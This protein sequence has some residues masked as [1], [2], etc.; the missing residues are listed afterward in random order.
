MHCCLVPGFRLDYFIVGVTNDPP[1]I[2]PPVR[3]SY[4]VCGQYPYPAPDG[5]RMVQCCDANTPPGRYVIITTTCDRTWPPD[6]L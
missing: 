6:D 5:A 1:N 4:P 2:T 3:G